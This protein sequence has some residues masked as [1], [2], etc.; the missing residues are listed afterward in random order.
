MRR[1]KHCCRSLSR[2]KFWIPF[3]SAPYNVDWFNPFKHTTHSE[4]AIHSSIILLNLHRKL[5]YLQENIILVGVIL[6]QKEPPLLINLYLEPLVKELKLLWKLLNDHNSH[7][8]FVRAALICCCC[9]I[10]VSR[11]VC[12][13]VV[14]AALHGCSKCLLPFSTKSFGKKADYF[15][16]W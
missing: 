16:L 2:C 12:G 7:S 3:Q 10:P 14:H 15:R 5:R 1:P 9:D 13:F 4:G 8:V 6:G 11:K